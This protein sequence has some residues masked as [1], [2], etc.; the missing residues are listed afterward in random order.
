[1]VE[2]ILAFLYTCI[3]V[4][5]AR[6]DA[7]KIKLGIHIKHG[8]NAGVYILLCGIALYVTRD[9]YFFVALMFLRKIVFDTFLNIFRGLPYNYAS[10]TTTSIIDRLTYRL[11]VGLGYW[12]F[13]GIILLITIILMIL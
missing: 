10:K 3:N 9:L 7:Y 11:N 4:F 1:M 6:I 5:L 2:F 12:A 13:Y 8:M